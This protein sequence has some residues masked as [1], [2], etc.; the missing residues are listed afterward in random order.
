MP[1]RRTGAGV[2]AL[3]DVTAEFVAGAARPPHL[4]EVG[5]SDGRAALA[6]MQ[7]PVGGE[8]RR[9]DVP[10]RGGA[11]VPCAVLPGTTPGAVVVYLH[12][13]GWVMGGHHTHAAFAAEIAAGTGATVV[14]PEYA[15]APEYRYPVALHQV[16]DVID[17]VAGKGAG[18]LGT[19]AVAL[20]GDCAGATLAA[21]AL[22]SWDG[23]VLPEVIRCAVLVHPLAR[24]APDDRSATDFADGFGLRLRDVR[25]LWQQYA[26]RPSDR[27]DPSCDP[28]AAMRPRSGL[29]PILLI[30]AECDVNR[31]RAEDFASRLRQAGAPVT[32][33]R[34]LAAVHDFLVLDALRPSVI[35]RSARTQ[36]ADFLAGHL[37]AVPALQ[38]QPCAGTG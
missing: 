12:G 4:Y 33:V 15:N 21:A 20:V 30:T 22:L 38:S 36:V 18:E 5:V 24:P 2:V 26:P 11:T 28:M 13:G 10:V 31:D 16:S 25:H 8:V 7:A 27:D 29:P 19:E 37:G 1:R 32:A 6:Q 35:S 3:D 14:V 34:Y 17:W 23:P 9:L